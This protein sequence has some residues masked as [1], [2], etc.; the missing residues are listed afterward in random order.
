MAD[1]RSG[2]PPDHPSNVPL[3]L[4]LRRSPVHAGSEALRPEA[5]HYSLQCIADS[6]EH[7]PSIRGRL[8]DE[9]ATSLGTLQQ[10]MH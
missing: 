5:H 8:I 4:Q 1:V 9:H 6:D 7:L 10:Y 2:S 3:L